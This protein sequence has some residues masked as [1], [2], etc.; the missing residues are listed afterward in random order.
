MSTTVVLRVRPWAAPVALFAPLAVAMLLASA[1][2]ETRRALGEDCLKDNEC[3]S[4][5][6]SQLRCATAPP[7]VDA[8]VMADAATEDATSDV[9]G[10]EP[11]AADAPDGEAGNDAPTEEAADESESS[12]TVAPMDSDGSDD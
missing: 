6:C 2:M 11:D 3:L 5:I 8:Q 4:G 7:T 12:S 9:P 1:C 10:M